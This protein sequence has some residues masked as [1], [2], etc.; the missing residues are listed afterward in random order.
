MAKA[1]VCDM[2]GC[3]I[4]TERQCDPAGGYTVTLQKPKFLT[5]E[6]ISIDLCKNCFNQI[7]EISKRKEQKHEDIE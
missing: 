4:S 2:C 1:R 5:T 3:I 6:T 7:I